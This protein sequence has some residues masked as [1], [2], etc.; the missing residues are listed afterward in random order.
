MLGYVYP[1]MMMKTLQ[2][3]C[4]TPLYK[5]SKFSIRQNWQ[6]LMELTNVNESVDLKKKMSLMKVYK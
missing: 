3:L 1:N 5:I 4:Q 2:E 6:N